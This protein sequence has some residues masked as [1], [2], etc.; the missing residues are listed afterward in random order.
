MLRA[1][2]Y[3]RCSTEEESQ[4]DALRQQAAE[5][6]QSVLKQG[7]QL[8][9]EYIEAKSGTTTAN[10]SEYNRLYEELLSDKFDVVVIKSQ[11]RLMRNTKDWYL[12]IDRLV[13]NEKKL[14][15]YLEGKFY[16]ADDALITGIKAILAEEYSKELSRK[17]N[18]AH[19]YRQQAGKSFILPPQTYGLRKN[20]DGTI[21]LVE[22]EAEAIRIMFLLCKS[23][24]CIAIGHY[25]EEN[26]IY[27]RNG[28]PFKEEAIRR[29]IRNPI[30]C[31]TVIQNK[32]HFDF[33]TKKVVKLPREQ[34]VVHK[35]AVPAVVTEQEWKEANDAMDR[36][37][38]SHCL[39]KCQ[40]EN[41]SC[42]QRNL[43]KCRTGEDQKYGKKCGQYQLSGK[44]RC[45]E[46]GS[47]YYRRY[48]KR[49]KNQELVVEWKCRRYLQKGRKN[50]EQGCNNIHLNEEKLIRL[51][52]DVSRQYFGDSKLDEAC[53]IEKMMSILSEI[54]WKDDSGSQKKRLK[55]DRER[56]EQQK[57]RLLDRL[58][59]EVISN[60]DYKV[61]SAEI[62]QRILNINQQLKKLEDTPDVQLALEQ[63]LNR[64]R[65]RLEQGALRQ[66]EAAAWI[67]RI[68]EITVF[69][70]KL[71]I[72]YNP[73]IKINERIPDKKYRIDIPLKPDF[74]DAARKEAQNQR[75]MGYMRKD[76][77][78]TAKMIAEKE[79][80]SLAA[81]NA[82]IRRLRR[83]GRIYFEGKGGHG[84][85]V[86]A[87]V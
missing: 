38:V 59:D 18:N 2:T 22:K 8:V 73:Y 50:Q 70:E 7:W 6:R 74:S 31:G 67:D 13:S 39:K 44:I 55:K 82:G 56:Y 24:G 34:W 61:K 37:R 77:E 80:I 20:A 48:R 81:A 66:A 43:E 84:K 57:S 4:Q 53:L 85:W 83:Q 33:Q 27:D 63:R 9:D 78:I 35:D 45:G 19:Y 32:I 25:L 71:T 87:R 42:M 1:V 26:G 62:E 16:S 40:E 14:F 23:M 60:E 51:L 36:R 47:P 86:T 52:E 29:I 10:R 65:E 41:D 17:I 46:C 76:P 12:F 75:I 28:R 11:D 15:M 68:Q 69:P 5:S 3:C 58:L 72:V 54:L 30:R 49:Y 64:I 21:E 79:G